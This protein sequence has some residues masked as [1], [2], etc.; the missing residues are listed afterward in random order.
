[1]CKKIFIYGDISKSK[2]I[3]P[4]DVIIIIDD[5]RYIDD[6]MKYCINNNIECIVY[7]YGFERNSNYKNIFYK[8]IL[9]SNELEVIKYLIN[10]CDYGI[11]N[12]NDS[13]TQFIMNRL[14]DSGKRVISNI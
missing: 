5:F 10:D 2:N 14:I 12:N 7:H 4:N 6:N 8:N 1:M 11:I 13:T 9:C 3:S